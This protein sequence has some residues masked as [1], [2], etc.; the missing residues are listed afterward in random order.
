MSLPF[1]R[2]IKGK[3]VIVSYEPDG[4]SVRFI[5]ENAQLF[6]GLM[7][8]YRIQRSKKDGSVQLRFEGVDAT[9]LHY[10]SAAQPLGAE[11]RDQLLKRMGFSNIQLDANRPTMVTSAHPGA[12]T[13]GILTKGVDVHGR[14][15]AYV[16]L[17]AD[18]AHEKDGA[19]VSTDPALLSKTMNQKLLESGMAYPLFYTSMPHDDQQQFRQAAA[20]ARKKQSGVWKIDMTREFVLTD[21]ASIGPNGECIFPKMFRRCTDFLKAVAKGFSGD[22][23]NWLIS[24]HGDPKGTEDDQVVTHATSANPMEVRL[25]SVIQQHNNRVVFQPDLLDIVFIE[26]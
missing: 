12:V 24:T 11:A 23:V 17:E 18:V 21:Q 1:Y 26:K 22:L 8:S 3:F 9:E 2:F 25:S 13:G 14:P 16:L 7:R 15:I 4:D 19:T 6:Q 20:Q 10:G 5:A